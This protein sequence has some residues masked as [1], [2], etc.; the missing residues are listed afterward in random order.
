MGRALSAAIM[1]FENRREHLVALG[2]LAEE[3]GYD[4][5]ML[6]ETWAYDVTV[7][8]AEIALKTRRVR[9]GTGIAGV[10]NRSAA[11]L[12]MASATLA[13]M[14]DGRF[15]LGLG[16]STPQLVEGLHDVP[17]EPPVPRMRRTVS[18]VRALLR[19]ER[20]PL[21]V[22]TAA[23]PLRLNVPAPG[24][25]P[26]YLAALGDA[27]VRLAGEIADGWIPFLY[28]LRL[29]PQGI[30]RLREG[31]RR[32]GRAAL[33]AVCPSVPAVVHEDAVQARAGAA[34]FVSFY[35]VSM[36][37]FYRDSLVRFGF[38]KEVQAVLAANTPKFAGAVPPKAEAL[39]EELIVYGTPAEARRRLDRWYDA[40]GTM[41]GLLLQASL[42]PGDMRRTLEALAPGRA[43]GGGP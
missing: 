16:A 2:T 24:A 28:P 13:S 40:G 8:L 10:W 21:A 22:T 32:A 39:L 29:L 27:S 25:V 36:G 14:S 9:L 11:T 37:T 18:Q 34:W 17:F 7:L 35:L 3:L 30:E 20:M 26:I 42:S 31:A 15:I 33:P 1:P 19:G 4:A 23:R 41:P 43:Q 38:D 6:P 5:V 12:A